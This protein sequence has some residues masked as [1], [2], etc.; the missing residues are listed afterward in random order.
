MNKI[1]ALIVFSILLNGCATSSPEENLPSSGFG[2]RQYQEEM[3]VPQKTKELSAFKG[4]QT[5]PVTKEE[6][7]MLEQ[8]MQKE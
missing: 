5:M 7:E 8:D 2:S 4:V 1:I 3:G 6:L